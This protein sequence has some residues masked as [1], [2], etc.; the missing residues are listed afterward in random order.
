[1]ATVYNGKIGWHEMIKGQ[2]IFT[3]PRE[4]VSTQQRQSLQENLTKSQPLFFL[5]QPAQELRKNHE[6]VDS[7]PFV[8]DEYEL[9]GSA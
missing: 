9:R 5:T 3:A 8:P 4:I 7:S 2:L 1:M 6:Q